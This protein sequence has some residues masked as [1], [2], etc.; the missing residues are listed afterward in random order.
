MAGSFGSYDY[1]IVGAGTAG[2]V[3]ANRLS[4]DPNVTV[5]LLEAGGKDDYIWTKIPVGYLYCIGNPKV[6][7]GFKTEPEPGLNGRAIDY[8]RGKVLGG[9]SSINGM[10]YMR[11]QA[12]DYDH[13]AQLGNP[14]WGWDDVLPYFLKSEDNLALE[15]SELHARGGEWRI[16]K[17]RLSWE[18]LDAFM[19]AAQQAGLPK[20][21]D[22]NTGDNEGVG[23][24]HVNQKRG[25]RWNTSRGFLK[26]IRNRRNL[27]VVT[28]AHTKRVTLADG[29]AAGIV[30]DLNGAEQT[31]DAKGE[32]IL[33]AGAVASPTILQLSGIGPGEVLREHGLHVMH[34]LAGVG[35]NLQDHLQIRCAYKVEGVETLNERANSLIGKLGIGLEYF[36]FQRGPMTMAPSQL[37]AFAKSDSSYDTPN[38]QYHVQ[39]L[40]LDKFGEPL[41]TFPAFTASVCNLRPESRGTIRIKS[42]DP[43]DSPAIRPN[44]LSAERDRQVAAQAVRYTRN[45]VGQAA[46]AKY[47]PQEFKPG[48]ELE[49]QEDLVKAAGDISSTI[50]HPIGTCKMGDDPMAVVDGRLRVH[51][52]RGLRVVDASVMPTITSGNTNSPTL[53]IAEKAA[54]M[55]KADRLQLPTVSAAE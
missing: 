20:V 45:I 7:W 53:M 14:G 8:P 1:I 25:W 22:F 26:P 13:W 28:G 33:A 31:A 55:I 9:C 48:L 17:P 36:L 46:L 15:P 11:G 40:T 23:Y 49:T 37:G 4:A 50:F 42:A 54:E 18:I 38:I 16:E 10:I 19:E 43:Y 30:F 35:E 12:R 21:N 24:F 34:E 51:G 27:R 32:I 3:L 44:Y 39:P 52:L 5:L 29:R 47:R 2:C 6:D 41:H